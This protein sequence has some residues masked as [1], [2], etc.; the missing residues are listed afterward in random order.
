MKDKI[1]ERV[2]QVLNEVKGVKYDYGCVMLYFDIPNATWDKVQALVK[3]EDVTSLGDAEG[4]EHEPH[5]TILYGL[6]SD[7]SDETIQ[8]LV[9]KLTSPT[10]KLKDISTFNNEEFDV[11][12]FD[13]EGEDLF[14]MNKMFTELPHTTSY[15]DY[16]PHTTIAYVKAGEGN[17]YRGSINSPIIVKP[18][19]VVYSKANGE[20]IE[21]DFNQK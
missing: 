3:D 13:V 5:V 4:R 9:S 6:H 21:Y 14:K 11:V 2:R 17:K 10:I 18:S 19:K 7:I 20:K 15:P 1:K 16:H 8:N 12:K